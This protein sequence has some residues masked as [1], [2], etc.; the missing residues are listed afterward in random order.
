MSISGSCS[1]VGGADPV[2]TP[3]QSTAAP[4]TVSNPSPV[5]NRDDA[6]L[7]LVDLAVL[8]DL[9]DQLAH[10]AVAQNFAR[11]YATLWTQRYQKLAGAMDR[12]DFAAAL[13]AVISM[14][15]ASA[16]VGGLR[17]SRLAE[18]L[19]GFIRNG[20]LENGLALIAAVEVHG[21][22]TVKELQNTY[23]LADE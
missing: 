21:S 1:G 4:I 22:A 8:Q 11:D 19:E 14:K 2:H 10:P 7:P 3:P 12:Q 15:I 13:D 9:S 16:M 5:S 23:I 20:D 18:Q 6:E 17:L